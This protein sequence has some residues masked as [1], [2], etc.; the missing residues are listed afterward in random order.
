MGQSLFIFRW[1]MPCH[2]TRPSA[3]IGDGIACYLFS[4]DG[5]GPP[6]GAGSPRYR[7]RPVSGSGTEPPKHPT[8]RT[9]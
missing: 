3:D 4:V 1:P 5:S 6:S 9:I 8:P 2:S 7:M